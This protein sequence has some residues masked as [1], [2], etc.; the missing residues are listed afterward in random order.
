[1][2]ISEIVTQL[3]QQ[4]FGKMVSVLTRTLGPQNLELAEDVVQEALVEA[5][6]TWVQKG[7]PQN[8]RAW[9][10]QV[11]KNKA[12]NV[13]RT[14]IRHRE[15]EPQVMEHLEHHWASVSAEPEVYAQSEIGDDQLRMIF[16]CCHPSIPQDAQIALTL[17]T[18]CGFSQ[19]QI[20]RAFLAQGETIKKRLVRARA[21]FKKHQFEIPPPDQ[22][23]QRLDSVLECV[24]L[25]F[26]EGYHSSADQR[27]ISQEL[28]QEAVRL[29]E[30]LYSHELMVD[31]SSLC[32]LLSLMKFNLA[33]SPSRMDAQGALVALVDQDRSLWNQELIHQGLHYLRQA[34]QDQAVGRFQILAAIAGHYTTAPTFALTDWQGIHGLYQSLN[35]FEPSPLVELNQ[36]IILAQIEGPVRAIE[37]L[38][39]LKLSGKLVNYLPFYTALAELQSQNQE[40]EAAIETLE[41]AL[42][43][44]I[45]DSTQEILQQK[46]NFLKK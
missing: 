5:M 31:K 41:Q 11:A 1:M 15:L 7:L 4:D 42:G 26:N 17:R 14:E 46:I 36:A 25:I 21:I 23:V 20:A 37:T 45:S 44:D 9:V 2:N 28:C 3:Y 30:I 33:R 24:F 34:M 18:L 27:F 8:P 19:D 13:V 35:Q 32:A 6:G 43:L 22:L 29:V 16:C 10:Y 38:Q 40:R 12:V 39:A